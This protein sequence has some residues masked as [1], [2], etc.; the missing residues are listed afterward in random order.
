MTVHDSK[1]NYCTITKTLLLALILVITSV[2]KPADAQEFIIECKNNKA[3]KAYEEIIMYTGKMTR[4][5]AFSKAKELKASTET[6]VEIAKASVA[7]CDEEFQILSKAICNASYSSAIEL[8]GQDP[9]LVHR[10]SKIKFDG[11]SD[12]K[13]KIINDLRPFIIKSRLVDID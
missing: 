13:A 2:G 8:A 7:L 4:S 6:A 11:I 12:I 1:Q 9:V 5:C 10:V 3:S